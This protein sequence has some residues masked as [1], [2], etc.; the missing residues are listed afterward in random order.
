MFGLLKKDTFDMEKLFLDRLANHLQTVPELVVAIDPEKMKYRPA[1]GKWSKQ[2]ILGHLADSALYNLS[3]F[4]KM[5]LSE[6]PFEIIPYPQEELV[7]ANDY[8]S[9]KTADVLHLWKTLNQQILW[10][11]K[12][13]SEKE[14]QIKVLDPKF[15]NEGDLLWW[16]EDYTTHLEHHLAQIL[17]A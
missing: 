8:Q 16:I 15:G 10:V 2:E 7:K 9:Q 13:Y 12:N 14:L 5:K 11:W 6:T 4:T 1:P 3:R 17:D